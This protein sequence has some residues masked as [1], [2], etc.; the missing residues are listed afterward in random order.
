MWITANHYFCIAINQ[1]KMK[2]LFFLTIS[3]LIM[4]SCGTRQATTNNKECSSLKFNGDGTFKIAQFTDIH[5]RWK[6][7]EPF[8]NTIGQIS[9]M[10]DTEKPDLVVFTGDIVTSR[11]ADTAWREVFKP[12]AERNIPFVVSFGNHDREQDISA[13]DMADII[14]S[15]PT[16]LNTAES[17]T[18]DDQAIEIM[19]H[20]GT[21]VSALIYSF[22]SNDYSTDREKGGY[23]WFS[24]S[25][26][27]N[28][29]ETSRKYTEGNGGVPLP[30]LAFFHIALLEHNQAYNEHHTAGTR[31]EDECPGELNTGMFGAFHECGDVMGVFVGHDHDNDYTAV[32]DGI[33]LGF[34]TFSGSTDPYGKTTYTNYHSGARMFEL[35]EGKH[36]FTTWKRDYDGEEYDRETFSSS[37][38]FTFHAAEKPSGEEN[39]LMF[40]LNGGEPEKILNP[41]I[42]KEFGG[43]RT[44]TMDGYLEIPESGL[45]SL[46]Y[47]CEGNARWT[48]D[49]VTLEVTDGDWD[50][51]REINLEKG[52]HPVHVELV[53]NDKDRL[54]FRWHPVHETRFVNIPTEYWFVK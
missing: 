30:A 22:D 50:A 26:V 35:K 2:H 14:M 18:L 1:V 53:S 27:I 25:Q 39:G 10:L 8:Q 20:D 28:Y 9:R 12:L 16:N 41:E 17:G 13:K 11:C 40:T 3:A 5:L 6:S 37:K 29:V 54:V 44:I 33:V 24:P 34:G 48:I 49:D 51:F 4:I 47:L 38:D 52:L 31:G 19:S 45:W 23:G 7:P 36:S 15:F 42:W 21:K 43:H 32:K 46:F